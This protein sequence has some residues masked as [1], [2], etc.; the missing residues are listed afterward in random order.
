MGTLAAAP[1]SAQREAALQFLNRRIDYE[2]G[3]TLSYRTRELKLARMRELLARIGDPHAAMPIVHVA[4]TKGK[5]ST[6][7][8]IA[9][10]LS[11]AGHRTGLF[12]SPHLE[13]I[14]ERLAIDGEP[15]TSDQFVRLLDRLMPAIEVM[16]RQSA[17][18]TPPEPGPTYFEITTA[19]ACLHFAECGVAAAVLEVGLGGRLDSTNVCQPR[20]SVITSIS[21][22][23]TK[24]LGNT[25]ESIAKEK[26]GIIKRGVPVVSGVT[27]PGPRDVIRQTCRRRGCRLAELGVDFDFRY[28]P[29]RGLDGSP[30]QGSIDFRLAAPDN[31]VAYADVALGLLGSHQGANAAVALAAIAELKRT[32]WDISEGAIRQGLARLAWPARVELIARRP[33]VVID[34]AHNVASV[35]ALIRV[36]DESFSPRRRLLVFLTTQEKDIH[37]MLAELLGPRGGP[38]IGPD[39]SREIP[40]QAGDL[41]RRQFD[42]VILTRYLDNPRAV[43]VEELAAAASAICP[44]VFR[45]CATPAEAWDETR[46][47]ASP[48]DL[49]CVTGSFFTAA[50]M[51]HEVLARPYGSD[52]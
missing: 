4:G 20:V 8:M 40:K 10:V 41:P 12:T 29:P 31:A 24:Q 48:D 22:D 18:R 17:A 33:A 36:L 44:G 45:V 38:P 37:G 32:G 34:A 1:I 21:F 28:R 46:R 7:A 2:R 27:D 35:T 23:H 3:S 13:R 16:D 50:Q 43:P 47:L 51:R 11:A 9:A 15:C 42:E 6:S 30:G 26:A 5:G 52:A 14:E 49:I 39:S 25:L 19:M